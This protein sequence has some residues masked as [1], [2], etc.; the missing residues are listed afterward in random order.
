MKQL[1]R[2]GVVGLLAFLLDYGLLFLLT[3]KFHLWYLLAAFISF[4]VSAVFNYFASMRLVFSGSQ[5]GDTRKEFL[6]FFAIT[7]VGL[8]M[9]HLFLW[10]LVDRF[11]IYYKEAKIVVTVVVMGWNYFCRKALLDQNAEDARDRR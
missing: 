10:L 9:N 3:E 11:G 5:D 7:V 6:T 8:L 1:G 4:S 2:F